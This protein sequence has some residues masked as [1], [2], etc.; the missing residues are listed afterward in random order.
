MVVYR[1]RASSEPRCLEREQEVPRQIDGEFSVDVDGLGCAAASQLAPLERWS[2]GTA[3]LIAN[4]A[5]E[6][7]ICQ[8]W[9][10]I[11]AKVELTPWDKFFPVPAAARLLKKPELRVNGGAAVLPRVGRTGTMVLGL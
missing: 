10:T 8:H 7:N 4:A 11:S 5:V 2:V 3:Q 9:R 1:H 6:R